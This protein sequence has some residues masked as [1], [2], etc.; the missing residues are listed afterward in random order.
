MSLEQWLVC[1]LS[2]LVHVSD[3]WLVYGLLVIS[4]PQAAC[5]RACAPWLTDRV[6][7]VVLVIVFHAALFFVVRLSK[8]KAAGSISDQHVLWCLQI[9]A[10]LQ[11]ARRPESPSAKNRQKHFPLGYHACAS[12]VRPLALLPEAVAQTTLALAGHSTAPCDSSSTPAMLPTVQQV[13]QSFQL[14]SPGTRGCRPEVGGVAVS[15]T[16]LLAHTWRCAGAAG[17]LRQLLLPGLPA[18]EGL[19]AGPAAGAA[20]VGQALRQAVRGAHTGASAGPCSLPKAGEPSSAQLRLAC[21]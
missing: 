6:L 20:P 12:A 18:M 16:T 4:P 21:A 5:F 8:I 19:P 2:A 3:M 15:H 13:E 7:Q 10:G 14:F 1:C 9:K 17:W 11:E